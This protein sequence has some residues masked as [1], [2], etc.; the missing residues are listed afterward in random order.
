MIQRARTIRIAIVSPN[1]P[2]L[3]V[4]KGLLGGGETFAVSIARQ[5]ADLKHEVTFLTVSKNSGS[6]YVNE[7][8][9][10]RYMK[11]SVWSTGKDDISSLQ[12]FQ[13]LKKYDVVHVQQLCMS[14]TLSACFASKMQKI[15]TF[16]TDHAGGS[17]FLYAMPQFCAKFPNY[18][19]PISEYSSRWLQSLSPST[20]STV[21]YGGVN[22]EVFHPNYDYSDINKRLDLDGYR[23]I[24]FVGRVA[25]HKGIEVLIK[26]FRYLPPKSKL[27]IVGPIRDSRYMAFLQET[28][29]KFCPGRMLVLGAV[30]EE[31]LPKY[32]NACDVFVLP[33]V[34]TDYLG[35][36]HRFPELLGLVKFEAMACSKPVIVSNVGGLPEQVINGENGFVVASGNEEQLAYAINKVLADDKHKRRMGANGLR[37]VQEKFTWKMTAKRILHSYE[38]ALKS[39]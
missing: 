2:P 1:A 34:Y 8:L 4:F 39:G 32:Y 7:K 24:L 30:P 13:D 17:L 14:L 31:D 27:L 15:P 38:S 29:K 3:N 25:P 20:K 18:F 19:L 6:Y 11:S 21:V 16:L 5:L 37:L 28:A 36:Y 35:H 10:F 23:V 12:I 26:A 33:S 9:N 22:P